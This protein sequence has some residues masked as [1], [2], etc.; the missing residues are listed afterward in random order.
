MKRQITNS[1]ELQQAVQ[2]L[3]RRVKVQEVEIKANY[4]QV[5]ENL[6]LKNV[7]KNKFEQIAQ[8][9][10]MQRTLINTAFGMVLGFAFKRAQEV[11]TE[12][13]L[14]RTVENIMNRSLNELEQRNPESWVS[15]AVTL[16]RKYTPIDSPIYPLVKYRNT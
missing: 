16:V 14:N 1:T 7:M 6:T 10:E 5:K 2:E 11:L 3:E 13:T 12:Q 8:T 4:E 9:P 15:K